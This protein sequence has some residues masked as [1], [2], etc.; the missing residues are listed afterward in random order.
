MALQISS[1]VSIYY[2]HSGA[3]NEQGLRSLWRGNMI[4]CWVYFHQL[5]F[6]TILYDNV[7]ALK[8]MWLE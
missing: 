4:N 8:K 2:L 5:F 6:Q 7:N 1:K 3:P